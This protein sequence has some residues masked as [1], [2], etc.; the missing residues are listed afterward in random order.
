MSE[1]ILIDRRRYR[2]ESLRAAFEG[3][4]LEIQRIVWWGRWLVPALRRQR[5]RSR[6]RTG[7]SP[8][9]VYRRYLELP[10]RPLPWCARAAFAWEQG[11]ALRGRLGIGTSLFAVARHAGAGGPGGLPT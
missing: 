6:S 8:G 4:G 5:S 2:P 7:D 10:P 3:C 9:Q 1:E 11:P